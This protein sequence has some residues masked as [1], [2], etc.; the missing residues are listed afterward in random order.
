[1]TLSAVDMAG[2]HQ[3]T[4]RSQKT[5]VFPE[6]HDRL[7]TNKPSL[8]LDIT[9]PNTRR[10]N[11]KS[12][13]GKHWQDIFTQND[14]DNDDSTLNTSTTYKTRPATTFTNIITAT[15]PDSTL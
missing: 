15:S 1:M 11:K 12:S 7:N 4:N 2:P 10:Q 5:L 8:T 9:T 14:I 3:H 6:T 13:I